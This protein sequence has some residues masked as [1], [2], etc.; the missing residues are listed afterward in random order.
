M[1]VRMPARA[2]GMPVRHFFFCCFAHLSYCNSEVEIYTSKRMVAVDRDDIL[3]D[4]DN[5][6]DHRTSIRIDSKLHAPL[7]FSDAI[8]SIAR[9]VQPQ[10]LVP[11]AVS[12][13]WRESYL[14][15]IADLF[16]V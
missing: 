8:E 11:L 14:Q 6:H 9:D 16:A 2:V 5:S 3:S 7:Q 13:F 4:L 10:S 1:L 12:V 15:L